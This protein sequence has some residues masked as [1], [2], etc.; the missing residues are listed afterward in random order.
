MPRIKIYDV[1]C[2]VA[3]ALALAWAA[4]AGGRAVW[5]VRHILLAL[6]LLP[7]ANRYLDEMAEF[8]RLQF[9]YLVLGAIWMLA[10][11]RAQ[12]GWLLGAQVE[13]AVGERGT[14]GY[15]RTT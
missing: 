6:I 11:V 3:P 14:G 13:A 4:L 15:K 5:D 7:F 10:T 2:A 12:R 1:F 8:I 9:D